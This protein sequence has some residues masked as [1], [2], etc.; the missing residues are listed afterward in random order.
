MYTRVL[1][2]YHE[3]KGLIVVSIH[4]GRVKTDMGGPIADITTEE[5]VQAM[6]D[7]LSKLSTKDSGRC[8]DRF[9]KDIPF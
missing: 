4:P 3:N 9:G 1:N 2:R 5:S 7:S 6:I 8:I